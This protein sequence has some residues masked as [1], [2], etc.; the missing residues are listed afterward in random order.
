MLHVMNDKKLGGG[1]GGSAKK[2]GVINFPVQVKGMGGNNEKKNGKDGNGGKKGSGNSKGGDKKQGG[3]G[4]K[5][6]KDGKKGG[7]LLGWLSRSTSIGRGGSKG[8]RRREG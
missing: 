6:G 4:K 3:K 2:G 5:E 8:R 7:G 1:G